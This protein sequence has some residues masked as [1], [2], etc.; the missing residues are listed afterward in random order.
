MT[1][2]DNIFTGT[3]TADVAFTSR[4]YHTAHMPDFP[5]PP[6]FK[7]TEPD[8]KP[9]VPSTGGLSGAE[10]IQVNA[11][12]ATWATPVLAGAIAYV[13]LYEAYNFALASWKIA[14]KVARLSQ[15]RI[16]VGDGLVYNQPTTSQSA[17]DTGAG[18][19]PPPPAVAPRLDP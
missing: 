8:S 13:A 7:H 3:D 6:S 9:T 10:L 11:W 2:T 1:A 5:I 19:D 4:A 14:N 17:D 18:S 16:M 12:K 15:W